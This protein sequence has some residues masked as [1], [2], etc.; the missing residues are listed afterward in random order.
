MEASAPRLFIWE[1]TELRS[2]SK[3][4]F[5][6]SVGLV[7]R[8]VAAP[9]GTET[10]EELFSIAVGAWAGD[11]AKRIQIT[12]AT[13]I[14]IMMVSHIFAVFVIKYFENYC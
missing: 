11:P 1:F 13:T 12:A 4:E 14:T 6:A 2:F 5:D 3:A 8:P 9:V 7:V 10:A